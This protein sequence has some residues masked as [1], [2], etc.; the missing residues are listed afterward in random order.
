MIFDVEE[1][2]IFDVNEKALKLLIYLVRNT[3]TYEA[4]QS[5]IF[6][7]TLNVDQEISKKYA[8]FDRLR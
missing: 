3:S 4:L 2:V 5:G 6:P 7:L 1:E 8:P